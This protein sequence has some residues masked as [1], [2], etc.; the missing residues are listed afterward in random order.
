MFSRKRFRPKTLV[1]RS[2][3][4]GVWPKKDNQEFSRL[5]SHKSVTHFHEFTLGYDVIV[6]SLSTPG[7]ATTK[8]FLFVVGGVQTGFPEEQPTIDCAK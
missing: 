3:E 5:D 8:E 6:S 1:F 2:K 4:P 7:L